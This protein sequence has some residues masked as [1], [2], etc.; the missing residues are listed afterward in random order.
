MRVSFS[1]LLFFYLL[2]GTFRQTSISDSCYF[3]PTMIIIIII[4][5]RKERKKERKKERQD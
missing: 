5:T 2:F 1:F 3:S 4:T